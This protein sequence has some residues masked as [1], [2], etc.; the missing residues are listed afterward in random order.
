MEIWVWAK[1]VIYLC[2]L[3]HI[4]NF[5]SFCHICLLLNIYSALMMMKM[6]ELS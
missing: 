5:G 4:L 1:Y 6:Q 2:E 3:I